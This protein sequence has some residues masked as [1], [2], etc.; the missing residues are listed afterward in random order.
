[1]P[2]AATASAVTY[3]ETIPLVQDDARRILADYA[4]IRS[5]TPGLHTVDLLRRRGVTGQFVLVETGSLSAVSSGATATARDAALAPLLI[6]PCDIRTHA[7]LSVAPADGGAMPDGALWVVTH[8]DVVPTHK[9]NG[10]ARVRRLAGDSRGERGCLRF[11]A[12]QQTD[13]PNHMTL[14]EVWADEGAHD[15]HRVADDTRGFRDLLA[16]FS[17]A[18]YDER[19]YT[20][21]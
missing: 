19:V 17:G 7:A 21:V 16:S 1:M 20:R 5:H 8:V 18:L 10:V 13:R 15:D 9:D 12:W 14:V 11:E 6:A 2:N 3:V 4:G